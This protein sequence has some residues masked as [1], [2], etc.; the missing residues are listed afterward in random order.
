[1]SSVSSDYSVPST[2]KTRG[3]PLGGG[4]R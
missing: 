4:S 2:R 1:L 3:C